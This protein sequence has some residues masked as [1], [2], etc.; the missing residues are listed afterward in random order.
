[1]ANPPKWRSQT[2][3]M[4]E[5]EEKEREEKEE[6]GRKKREQSP[7]V[8]LGLAIIAMDSPRHRRAPPREASIKITKEVRVKVTKQI[9]RHFDSVQNAKFLLS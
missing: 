9:L 1:M 6:E 5:R 4:R 2:I 7:F 3:K 8:P